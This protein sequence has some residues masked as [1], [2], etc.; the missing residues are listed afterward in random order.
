ML[1]RMKT[2]NPAVLAFMALVRLK[3][4]DDFKSAGEEMVTQ[5]TQIFPR[6][7]HEREKSGY[8]RN[9]CA[10]L[11]LYSVETC[12]YSIHPGWLVWR[13]DESYQVAKADGCRT[14]YN[15]KKEYGH[16]KKSSSDGDS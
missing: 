11:T 14:G 7:K 16:K 2:D 4:R 6:S 8:T 1:K 12:S 9:R 13:T 15:E 10:T 3:H 5:I